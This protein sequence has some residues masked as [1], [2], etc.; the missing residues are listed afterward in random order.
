[1]G[2]A[3]MRFVGFRAWDWGPGSRVAS[4]VRGSLAGAGWF[5]DRD[6]GVG[7]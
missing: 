3:G 6:F 1:M 7:I 2:L 4:A 5:L